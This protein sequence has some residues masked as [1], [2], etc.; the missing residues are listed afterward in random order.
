MAK[1]SVPCAARNQ[2]RGNTLRRL[3]NNKL[4]YVMLIP[5][6]AN[7]IIF[8]YLPFADITIA[9]KQYNIVLGASRS[10]WVGWKNFE[11]FFG[12]YYF[13][14]VLKNTLATSI[15]SIIF[16]FP[17][18]ILLAL[19]L[20]ESPSPKYKSF[21]QSCSYLPYFV[22]VV[23]CVGMFKMFLGVDNGIINDMIAALGFERQAFL[24]TPAWF[25]FVY[26][27]IIV[28]RW[29]GYD[30]IVYLAAMTSIDP[31]LYEAAEIDGAGRLG[32]IWHVTLPG[33]RTTIVLLLIMRL[34]GIMNLQWQDIL[35]LQNDLNLGVSEVIQTFVYKRGMLKADYSYATAVGLF[36]SVVGF[37]FVLAANFI[38]K[39]LG[40]TSLF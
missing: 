3:W 29:T 23:V 40:D 11:S 25:L 16:G 20:N 18:P 17:M 10:P 1:S 22:S 26:M 37:T 31:M 8:H 14:D 9:F 34:G 33:I 15:C 30:A 38:S 7:F 36:Q 24:T 6:M 5:V 21:V 19:L 27:L 13:W 35:L 39:K 12:S 2:M 4:L 32:R 28:W